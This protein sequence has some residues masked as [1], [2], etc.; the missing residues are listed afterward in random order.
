MHYDKD[1]NGLFKSN[2]LIDL[3]GHQDS[4]LDNKTNVEIMNGETEGRELDKQDFKP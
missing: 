3:F 1:G 4:R 2:N